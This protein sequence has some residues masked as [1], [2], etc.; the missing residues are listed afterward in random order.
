M[1]LG[2]ELADLVLVA[3]TGLP[4]R[5]DPV[6]QFRN[7]DPESLGEHFQHWKANVFLSAFDFGDVSSIDA[8]PMGH[9]DLRQASL[10]S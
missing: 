7:T 4:K 6:H 3:R 10:Y 2:I 1:R 5:L 9:F 8:K